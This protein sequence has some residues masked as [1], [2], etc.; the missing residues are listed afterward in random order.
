MVKYYLTLLLSF[1]LSTSWAQTI[2]LPVEV[3]GEQGKVVTRSVDLTQEQASVAAKIWMQVNNLS[4]ENKASIKVNNGAW[5]DLNHETVDMQYQEKARGGMTHGGFSTV[6]FKL[7]ASGFVDGTNT[8]S[9][10]FNRSDGISIGYRVVKFNILD[11]VDGHL[12]DESIFEEEDPMDW[13]APEGYDTPEAIAAGKDLWDNADL[14]SNYL[15]SDTLGTWYGYD[16]QPATPINAKCSD[17]HITNGFDLE[18]FSYSNE[19]II[20]RSVFHELTEDEGKKIAAYIRSLSSESDGPQRHG[21]PWNPPYQPGPSLEGKPLEM[22]AAG[23]GLDAILDDDADMLDYMFPSGVDSLSVAEYFDNDKVEDRTLTPLAVHLPDWK[24]WLPLVHPKDAYSVNNFYE[25]PTVDIHPKIGWDRMSKYLSEMP[26]MERDP[27]DF[28]NELHI[29]HRHFRHFWDQASGEVR[30]WRTAGDAI[31]RGNTNH[32]T[33]HVPEG[34]PIEMT[35]TSVARLLAVKNFEIMNLYDLQDKN[36]WF[37]IPEDYK[38]LPERRWQWLGSD[39]NIF[40]VP[41][42]FTACAINSNCDNFV[43]QLKATGN[44]ESTAWYQLQLVLNG[45]NGNVGGNDPMDWQYQLSFIMRASSSSGIFEPVRLFHSI[46][47]M[48]QLRSY[49]KHKTPNRNG[50]RAR[51]QLPHWMYGLGDNNSFYGFAPGEFT[52]LLDKIQPGMTKLFTDAVLRQFLA[53]VNRPGM[54]LDGWD[55]KAPNGG[56]YELE[57]ENHTE[58]LVDVE[59]ETGLYFYVD[60]M[61]YLI[62]KFAA[63]GVDCEIIN[64]LVDWSSEAWPHYDWEQFRALPTTVVQLVNENQVGCE[65]SSITLTA[66]GSNQGSNPSYEWRINNVKQAGNSDTFTSDDLIAGDQVS[67]RMVGNSNC[68]SNQSAEAQYILPGGGFRTYTDKNQTGWTDYNNVVAC[69]DD[70]ITVKV[71]IPNEPRLWLDALE[72][73]DGNVLNEGEKV[74]SWHDRSENGYDV[75]ADQEALYPYYDPEGMNGMPAVMFGMENNADG[76]R[77]FTT[78]E[79]DF[80]ED[81]WSVV[82]V[83]EELERAGNWADIIGNKSETNRDDGWFIRF[84]DYGANQVSA[85][86]AFYQ[87][88]STALPIEFIAI[89]SKKDREITFTLNGRVT[90][91]FNM[92][93][94]EKITTDFEMFLGLSDK[95]NPESGRYHRGPISEVM[96]YDYALSDEEQDYL[97]GYLSHKWKLYESIPNDHFYKNNS[98]L[99]ITVELPNGSEVDLNAGNRVFTYDASNGTGDLNFYQNIYTCHEPQQVTSIIVEDNLDIQDNIVQFSLDNRDFIAGNQVEVKDEQNLALSPNYIVDDYQWEKPDGTMLA[100]NIDPFISSTANDENIG[101]WKLH[102]DF[103]GCTGGVDAIPFEV[104]YLPPTVYTISAAITPEGTTNVDGGIS[105]NEFDDTSVVVTPSFGY[106]VETIS[107]NGFTLNLGINYGEPVEFTLYEVVENQNIVVTYSE[108]TYY[109][110]ELIVG[111][112]GSSDKDPGIHQIGEGSEFST[113]FIPDEGFKVETVLYDG[114]SQNLKTGIT[115][116]DVQQNHK[117]EVTFVEIIYHTLEMVVGENGNATYATGSHQLEE[118]NNVRVDFTPDFG[119]V[120]EDAIIDGTSVGAVTSHTFEN[121]NTDHQIEVSFEEKPVEVITYDIIA[122]AGDNGTI[123]PEG[124]T[125]VDEGDDLTYN[126]AAQEGFLIDDVLVNG[127]SMGAI[128]TYTFENVMDDQTISASFIMDI[129]PLSVDNGLSGDHIYPNPSAGEFNLQMTEEIDKVVI[130]SMDGKRISFTKS[131]DNKRILLS[132]RE[133]TNGLYLVNVYLKNNTSKTFKLMIARR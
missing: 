33:D 119:Y 57:P 92:K 43:G 120:V 72:L 30:H 54:D 15:E 99:D 113:T 24:H 25:N 59:S 61:Y 110:I 52:G 78:E 10:R 69:A 67:V 130:I 129:P 42:H 38:E 49:E 41:P 98:P 108:L 51:Q 50:F 96:F 8:I 39:Y 45:G 103:G 29:M 82:V 114:N 122:S 4:Y 28:K 90:K 48:Y 100:S 68:I 80:M 31:A 47:A 97:E 91:K 1:L 17:C 77:L 116:S 115:I 133:L 75:S 89:L 55:R 79:D 86:G 105:I 18:Y 101:T 104:I 117:V 40:E 94:G 19:S 128:D 102:A 6:R 26:I 3:L 56:S 60:K 62:P 71:D 32:V 131:F 85:G 7:P 22:W 23:A 16:L 121:F 65:Q 118:G 111:A 93:E 95:G 20:E 76:L 126:I 66:I 81:D 5:L 70:D 58:Q 53:E 123:T 2:L 112:G 83:G 64:G 88:N 21:R 63:M 37:V 87:D 107:I 14:W 109:E 132:E 84:S 127:N 9:F 27:E 34:I 46:N 12:L 106:R 124:T 125:T 36:E 35:V 73:T 11:A 44:Y 74:T 13:T